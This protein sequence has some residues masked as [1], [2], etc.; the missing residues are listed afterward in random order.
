MTYFDCL[1]N[2]VVCLLCVTEES[3]GLDARMMI[4]NPKHYPACLGTQQTLT[5]PKDVEAG[6]W[7]V[8]VPPRDGEGSPTETMHT[9][10]FLEFANV[11]QGKDKAA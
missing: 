3:E 9:E 1:H 11:G 10:I 7:V 8:T 6:E 5:I 2:P 4:L